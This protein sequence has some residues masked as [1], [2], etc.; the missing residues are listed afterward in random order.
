MPDIRRPRI[1]PTNGLNE[2]AGLSEWKIDASDPGARRVKRF[3]KQRKIWPLHKFVG[4][5]DASFQRAVHASKRLRTCR[6]RR[7]VNPN[8]SIPMTFMTADPTN[9]TA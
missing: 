7:K 4:L 3:L 8:K 6:P 2:S 1:G 9:V 5:K